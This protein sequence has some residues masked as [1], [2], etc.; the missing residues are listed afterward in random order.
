MKKINSAV[1]LALVAVLTVLAANLEGTSIIKMNLSEMV[2]K[3]GRII[4]GVCTAIDDGTMP[5]PSGGS[6]AYTSYTF[7]VSKS[8]KGGVG[9]SLEIKQFSH[10][11]SSSSGQV[12]VKL[13]GMPTYQIGEEYV[14]ILTAESGLGLSTTVGLS[15]GCFRVIIN[16]KTGVRQVA[17]GLNNAGLFKNIS[18]KTLAKASWSGG[19]MKILSQKQGPIEYNSFLAILEKLAE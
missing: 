19:E 18:E 9:S 7:A 2:Q 1:A 12:N 13:T 5:T 17:N 11:V 8:I 3:S 15:Q 4:V 6:I 10:P 16:A 14:L